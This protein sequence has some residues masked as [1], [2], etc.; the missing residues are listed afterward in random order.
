MARIKDNKLVGL[1]G[2]VVSYSV[3]NKSYARS[4]AGS[5]RQTKATKASAKVFGKI[6]T[7][8][9][10]LRA[11]LGPYLDWYASKPVMFAMDAAVGDWYRKSYPLI[12]STVTD[13]HHFSFLHLNKDAAPHAQ[14]W[15]GAVP[16]AA[17]ENKKF[18]LQIPQIDP[19]VIL[20]PKEATVVSYSVVI[21][22]VNISDPNLSKPFKSEAVERNIK[23][24][25]LAPIEM[26]LDIQMKTDCLYLAFLCIRYKTVG[27]WI[28]EAKWKPVLVVG[29]CYKV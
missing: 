1:I 3:N 18:S 24:K 14:A 12:N 13:M 6:K 25:S 26:Q 10:S 4:N 21:V 9:A 2:N 27:R 23:G 5:V 19:S 17:W 11:A 28:E 8:S 20:M 15:L 22:S 7:I 29:S 16:V